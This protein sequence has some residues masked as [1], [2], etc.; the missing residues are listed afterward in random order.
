MVCNVEVL[1]DL[2]ADYYGDKVPVGFKHQVVNKAAH[3]WGV[4]ENILKTLNVTIIKVKLLPL[5]RSCPKND[6]F[7]RRFFTTVIV[8]NLK[9]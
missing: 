9:V 6:Y 5:H 3:R 8:L 4:E 2:V 1:G 7:C